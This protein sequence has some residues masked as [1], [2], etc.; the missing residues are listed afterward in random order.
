[1]IFVG[2]LTRSMSFFFLSFLK[3]RN[4]SVLYDLFSVL[5]LLLGSLCMTLVSIFTTFLQDKYYYSH[6]VDEEAKV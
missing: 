3:I 5:S 1:M 2:F 4:F 6:F